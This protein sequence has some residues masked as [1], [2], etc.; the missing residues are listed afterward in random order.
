MFPA[1]LQFTGLFQYISATSLSYCKF[2]IPV[3]VN[4]FLDVS[5]SRYSLSLP[6]MVRGF[7]LCAAACTAAKW[8]LV[9]YYLTVGLLRV[10]IW[11]W[12]EMIKSRFDEANVTELY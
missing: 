5:E 6:L 11:L 4:Y 1:G 2:C 9:R 10:V 3:C 8:V 12:S 7:G